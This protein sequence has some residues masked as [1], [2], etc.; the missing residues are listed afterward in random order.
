MSKKEIQK[1]YSKIAK[2]NGIGGTKTTF[3]TT[4]KLSAPA[5]VI[6]RDGSGGSHG[7]TISNVVRLNYGSP[8]G[9]TSHEILHTLGLPDNGYKSGGLLNSPPSPIISPEARKALN[10]SYKKD[11]K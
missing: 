10:I 6:T 5:A 2:E 3:G 1:E 7:T 8:K 11:E 9:T 4:T